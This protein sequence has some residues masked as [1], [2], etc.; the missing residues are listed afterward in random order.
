LPGAILVIPLDANG[1]P[2]IQVSDNGTPGDPTDDFITNMESITINSNNNFHVTHEIKLDAAGNLYTSNS[3]AER[4][5]VWSPGG[6]TRAITTSTGTFSVQT[7]AGV[8]G[9]FNNDGQ[10]N[11]ADINALTAEIAAGSTNLS[12]D[13]NGD[14]FI[15]PADVT[16][17]GDGWLAVGGAN[18]LGVTGGRPFLLGDANLNGTVNNADF[19]TWFANRFSNTAAWCSGDFNSDGKI[20]GQDFGHWNTNKGLSSAALPEPATTVSLLAGLL[21]LVLSRRGR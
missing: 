14:G 5:E 16:D 15:T 3:S 9:D 21:A 17:A 18:N 20:D 6:N 8:T 10:W 13:M 2:D 7:I 1:L 19:D 4:V 11:C 12:F